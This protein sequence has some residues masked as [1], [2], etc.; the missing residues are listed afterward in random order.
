MPTY[1]NDFEYGNALQYVRKD[2]QTKEFKY[3]VVIFSLVVV[4]FIQLY[5][6]AKML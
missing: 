6:Y 4:L 1:G 2:L 3:C 5:K